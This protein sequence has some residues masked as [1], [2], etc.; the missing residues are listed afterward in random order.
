MSETAT[1]D[2]RMHELRGIDWGE[3]GGGRTSSRLCRCT[4]TNE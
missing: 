4:C 3:M 2:Y 1:N